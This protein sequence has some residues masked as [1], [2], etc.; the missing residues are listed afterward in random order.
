M[1][2][3]VTTPLLQLPIGTPGANTYI[4]G[5]DSTQ[6]NRDFRFLASS[7]LGGENN[8]GAALLIGT[9]TVTHLNPADF[10]YA[11]GVATIAGPTLSSV[12]ITA[13]D[14]NTFSNVGTLL[15]AKLPSISGNHCRCT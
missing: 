13:F 5:V 3:P 6:Q 9:S 8:N 14:P 10:T 15:S 4:V 12:K 7:F 2:A 1:T 11:A